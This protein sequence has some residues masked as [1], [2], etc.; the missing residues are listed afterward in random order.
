MCVVMRAPITVSAQQTLAFLAAATLGVTLSAR[1]APAQD[2][3][4]DCRAISQLAG[5]PQA[6]GI[7]QR[8]SALRAQREDFQRLVNNAEAEIRQISASRSNAKRP[9]PGTPEA[10]IYQDV[11]S[12]ESRTVQSRQQ[13]VTWYRLEIEKLRRAEI[14]LQTAS[15]AL[16]RAAN[17][18]HCSAVLGARPPKANT[19]PAPPNGPAFSVFGYWTTADGYLIRLARVGTM[20]GGDVRALSAQQTI[21]G[22]LSGTYD[23]GVLHLNYSDPRGGPVG[24]YHL[25]VSSDGALLQGRFDPPRPAQPLAAIWQRAQ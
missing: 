3:A 11:R 24:T 20:V 23:G 6:P 9:R 21:I 16:R 2:L 4:A 14:S 18:R 12:V 7:E 8:L 15:T 25:S 19:P 22:T 17:A 10:K 5:S 1:D 13:D